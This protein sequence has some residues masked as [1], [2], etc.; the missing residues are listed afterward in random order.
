MPKDLHTDRDAKIFALYEQLVEIEQR[1]IPTGLHVFGRPSSAG[2]K[3][4]LL[5]MIASFDRP[6]VGAR[7]IPE[8]LLD[9][10]VR[11][12]LENGVD[13]AV[14]LTGE[15]SRPVFN[16]LE[17]VCTKLQ[18]NNEIDSLVRA[19]R[20]EY[21]EPG[22]G[23]DIIQNPDILPTG[24]NTHAINPYGVPSAAAFARSEAVANSLLDRYKNENGRYPEAMALVLWGLDNIKTQGEGVAQALWLL[25]TRPVR[26]ALNRTTSIEAIPLAEL[27]RPRIDVVMTVSGIFRDLFSPT[28]QL[29]DKA[30]RL[31]AQLD[32]PLELNYVRKHVLQQVEQDR[33]D[34]DDAA[35]R[36]FSNAPGNYGTN[37]N[38]MVM[39]S[40]WDREETLGDL[41]V[42][43]KCFAYGRDSTGRAF[44]GREAR[45]AM[46]R[47]LSR[48]EATYQNID[49]FEIGLTDVDH[50][51]EYLGGVSKAVEKRA[52]ARPAIYLSDS[53]SREVKIRS[54]EETVRLET[55]AKTLN[56]KW[57][58][59]MLKHGFR[60]VAEIENHVSN[61]FGWSATADAVDDWVYTE[62]ANTFLFDEQMLERLR[63]LNPHSA[64]SLA[65]RLLEANGRGY[66]DVEA[67]VLDKLRE[68]SRDLEDQLEGVV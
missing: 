51:F 15:A 6:E 67:S 39:D 38:F 55:R 21:I 46:D 40:Q 49:T 4:D 35:V 45:V 41:F 13:A 2:E 54:L 36:V 47:A 23:A 53:L 43:R 5:K 1:L 48:V 33:C 27:G 24:R 28:V 8:E 9:D 61:T 60:G 17:T 44:E 32:E 19:L 11:V 10:A 37:V 62:V 50:Y 7:A 18:S 30:V 20:G 3:T 64:H 14:R 22:P 59:G 12:F 29:L 68:I 66:W 63:D 56:P 52:K 34:L 31:V 16:L 42:T 65:Q 57:Y 58:E 26:D 25:G